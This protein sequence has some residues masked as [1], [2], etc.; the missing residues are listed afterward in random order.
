MIER[1]SVPDQVFAQLQ[2]AILGGRYAPG[3]Q[4]PTQRALAADL[5]VNMAT[6][7]EALGRLEQLRLVETRHGSG[8]HV[9]DWR[10]SG[11][12]D[13]L[14]LLGAGSA[15][16]A[17]GAALFEARR[18][19][20][21]EAARLA[22]QRRTETQAR[23]LAELADALATAPDDATA[24]LADWS[25]MAALVE[26]AGNLVFQLIMNSVRELYLPHADAFAALVADR[27]E[28]LPL[29]ARVAAAVESGDGDGAAAAVAEL[30]AAQERRMAGGA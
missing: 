19:L 3:E 24:L 5:G 17:V 16:P 20:L 18:L 29:Y 8:T 15:D 21:A 11:G 7:R 26:A 25:F 9:R 2:Q 30:A 1:T 14:T 27:G 28:L 13:A 4:L 10:R 22:A 12:L 6:V 23:T